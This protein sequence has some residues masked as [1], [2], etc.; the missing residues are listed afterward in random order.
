MPAEELQFRVAFE[1]ALTDF[2]RRHP[3]AVVSLWCDWRREVV[4]IAGADEAA[5]EALGKR[6]AEV[7]TFVERYP[8]GG[9]TH[10][11]VMDCID[12]P[13]DFVYRAVDTA[14]CVH[15]PPTRFE[16]G[17]EH[18]TVMSF[19]EAR[20]RH[21]F[22]A[23]KEEGR[24]VELLQKRALK[25]QPLLNTRSIPLLALVSRL[26]DKQVDALLL[27]ARHGMY[28]SPRRTTAAAIADGVGLSRSTF[29]EHLRKAENRLM[30]DL[31]P[32]L[33]LTAKARRAAGPAA[34][35]SA[36]A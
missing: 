11:L 13:H 22:K 4:E 31:V 15:V 25:V 30:L 2:T 3:Q 7:S 33:E 5:V 24:A 29:E 20:S 26:T 27:A 32:Y 18:Y 9:G 6:L 28:D 8:L 1:G 10:V 12:L 35:A 23:L 17:Y 16:A 21:L 34:G 14:H 36:P 19:S